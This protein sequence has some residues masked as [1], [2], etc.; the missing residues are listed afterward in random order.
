MT[1]SQAAPAANKKANRRAKSIDEVSQLSRVRDLYNEHVSRT[2][3]LRSG[4]DGQPTP[5]A[6]G[7]PLRVRLDRPAQT[8]VVAASATADNYPVGPV[9]NLMVAL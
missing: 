9:A 2:A 3:V 5:R 6:K 8:S 1:A 7:G 4:R